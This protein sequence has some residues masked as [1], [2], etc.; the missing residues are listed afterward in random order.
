ME[1]LEASIDE[2]MPTEEQVVCY[3]CSKKVASARTIPR[4]N[5]RLCESCVG[6]GLKSNALVEV[7]FVK[8]K[9]ILNSRLGMANIL[10]RNLE[11]EKLQEGELGYY[12]LLS[13]RIHLS[14]G[15]RIVLLM[16]VV[17]HEYAHAWQAKGWDDVH[18]N[19]GYYRLTAEGFAV[20]VEYKFFEILELRDVSELILAAHND[21]YQTGFRAWR[22]L[23]E[24]KGTDYALKAARDGTFVVS[25]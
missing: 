5:M 9:E 12:S 15:M 24:K 3:L 13:G 18:K 11:L 23:E 7:L 6:K 19:L 4:T 20:W 16:G 2:L 14:S 17:A 25:R 10:T 21:F 1:E 22:E 8:V